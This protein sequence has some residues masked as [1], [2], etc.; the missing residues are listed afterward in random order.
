MHSK[1]KTKIISRTRKSRRKPSCLVH[2]QRRSEKRNEP[3]CLR[4][5]AADRERESARTEFGNPGRESV[6]L[7]GAIRRRRRA[8]GQTGDPETEE[9]MGIG[10]GSN[11]PQ[12]SFGL[13]IRNKSTFHPST[14]RRVCVFF[15]RTQQAGFIL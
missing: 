10:V 5:C 8:D 6:R 2:A 3:L 15:E 12:M 9:K 11:G 1:T 4:G 7:G 14:L 13:I